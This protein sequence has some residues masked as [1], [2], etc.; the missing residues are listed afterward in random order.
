MSDFQENERTGDL[1]FHK[2]GFAQ[3]LV[4]PQRQKSTISPWAAHRALNVGFLNFL[5]FFF[6]TLLM[7][8]VEPCWQMHFFY[9]LLGGV[10]TFCG[11]F[12]IFF[13]FPG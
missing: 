11:M 1:H 8:T 7:L 9:V 12:L 3:R 5:F 10:G 6:F 4:L 2:Y 13:S